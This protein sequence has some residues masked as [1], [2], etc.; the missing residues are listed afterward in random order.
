MKKLLLATTM[1]TLVGSMA[2]GVAFAE[3]TKLKKAKAKSLETDTT[4]KSEYD[5]DYI[6]NSGVQ[7]TDDLLDRTPGVT[8]SKG[9]AAKTYIRGIEN[10]NTHKS[11]EVGNHSAIGYSRDGIAVSPITTR[12]IR[13]SSWDLAGVSVLKGAQPT[14]LSI[15][16]MAGAIVV[17]T[18]DAN[19]DGQTIKTKAE[20]GQYNSSFF[21]VAVNQ[22]VNKKNS[23]SCISKS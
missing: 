15:P 4:V 12:Y 13:Q 11:N 17:N 16:T 9:Y 7:N 8:R 18:A 14:A 1:L 5:A 23:H 2:T 3:E 22:P 21:G 20:M 6:E 19:F 10:Y